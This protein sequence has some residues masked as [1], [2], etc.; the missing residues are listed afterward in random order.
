[1]CY[2]ATGEEVTAGPTAA[3]DRRDWQCELCEAESIFLGNLFRRV[4]VCPA[5]LFNKISMFTSA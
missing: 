5:L 2:S 1:M 3:A 4:T